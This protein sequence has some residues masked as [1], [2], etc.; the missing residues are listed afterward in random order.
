MKWRSLEESAAGPDVR[1]LREI[2][3][4]RKDLIAKYVPAE[5]Q[6]IHSRAI[7]ELNEKQLP[8]TSLSVATK[9]PVFQLQDQNA[10]PVSSADLLAKGRLVICFIR[11][12]WCPFCVGQLEAMNLILPQIK[13][14]RASLSRFRRRP[15]SNPSSWR[16]ST[17]YVFRCSA[18]LA[19]PWLVEFGLCTA[20][21]IISRKCIGG[22]LL[23][24]P[25]PTGTKVG[26]SR[27]QRPTFSTAT[28]RCC[29]RRS[30][31]TTPSAPNRLRFSVNSPR[32][33][34]SHKKGERVGHHAAHLLQAFHQIEVSQGSMEPVNVSLAVR[35]DRIGPIVETPVGST[36]TICFQS[37]FFPEASSN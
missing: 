1:P 14:A 33:S 30:M 18:I 36:G 17:S 34:S 19:T 3:A 16:I 26:N 4:E 23:T 22:Y 27:F 11:G 7:A 25:S 6:A 29:F 5:I 28:V 12:R 8:T 35:C 31:L 2:F 32:I 10:K 21:P 9:A 24:C 20:F 15:C 13:R 37:V